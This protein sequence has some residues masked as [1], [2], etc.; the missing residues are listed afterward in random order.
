MKK[1]RKE[2]LLLIYKSARKRKR[3][4]VREVKIR[5]KRERELK[6]EIKKRKQS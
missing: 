3:G 6:N 5:W 1:K 2:R 4:S